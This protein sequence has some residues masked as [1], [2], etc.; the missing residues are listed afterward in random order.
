M[1][2]LQ[3]KKPAHLKRKGK[4]RKTASDSAA[5]G[6]GRD[7]GNEL[8]PRKQASAGKK[9]KR[10]FSPAVRQ[11]GEKTALMRLL[12]KYFG[13]W[14]QFLREVR[15]EL[16]KVVWPT[17]KQTIGTTAVVIVFVLVIAVF[18]GLIDFTLSG[19]VRLIL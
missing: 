18:L 19:L 13:T 3:K 1:A 7:T 15:A 14:I 10:V 16:G 5:E 9:E 12:E 11:A 4:D 8:E 2:R 6:L 17:R